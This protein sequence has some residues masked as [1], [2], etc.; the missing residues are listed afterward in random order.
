VLGLAERP[1]NQ[2]A[3]PVKFGLMNLE[4]FT[5]RAGTIESD[6]IVGD[7][8]FARAVIRELLAFIPKA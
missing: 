8:W 7:V 5:R 4:W 2:P 6:A 3:S 1:S